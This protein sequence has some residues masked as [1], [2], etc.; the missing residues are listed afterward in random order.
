MRSI[1]E[2]DNHLPKVTYI[3]EVREYNNGEEPITVDIKSV[4]GFYH[5][6]IALLMQLSLLVFLEVLLG[7]EA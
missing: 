2:F 1:S 6:G 7:Y 5:L 4:H 3:A